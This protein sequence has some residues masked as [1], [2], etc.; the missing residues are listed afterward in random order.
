MFNWLFHDIMERL[1]G[2][3]EPDPENDMKR[4]QQPKGQPWGMIRIEVLGFRMPCQHHCYCWNAVWQCC[5]QCVK[6]GRIQKPKIK[7]LNPGDE[8]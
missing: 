8:R 7:S 4:G 2:K 1:L 5:E 6:E 3:M